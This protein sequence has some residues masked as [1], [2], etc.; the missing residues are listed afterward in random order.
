MGDA[1][2][3]ATILS[4]SQSFRRNGPHHATAWRAVYAMPSSLRPVS[5]ALRI[6][7]TSDMCELGEH[8][9]DALRL[10][11]AHEPHS[12]VHGFQE[13]AGQPRDRMRVVLGMQ[14]AARLDLVFGCD[15][16]E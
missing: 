8:L 10:Y 6:A 4:S 1:Q 16:R 13:I 15:E 11:L 14:A 5:I 7:R 9:F 12:A 3:V 2:S